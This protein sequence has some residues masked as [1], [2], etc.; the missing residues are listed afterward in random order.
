M[1]PWADPGGPPIRAAEYWKKAGWIEGETLLV[2]RRYADFRTERFADFAGELLRNGAELLYTWGNE[3]TVAAMRATATVPIVF[4]NVAFPVESGVVDSLARPGRNATGFAHFDGVESS[5]KFTEL[6][7]AL[8]PKAKRLA[9][10]TT[11]VE[12]RMLSPKG[13]ED[14]LTKTT[15]VVAGLGLERTIHRVRRIEEVHGALAAAAAGHA[16]V[17]YCAGWEY[18]G[19]AGQVVDFARRQRWVS[20]T[21]MGALFDAG[22]LICHTVNSAEFGRSFERVREMTDRIL[23]GARPADIPVELPRSI[24]IAFNLREARALGLTV[25]QSLLLRADRVVE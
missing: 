20:A 11:E 4:N 16:E 15:A 21:P 23:R 12:L 22:L 25:P 2:D 9:V 10:L 13:G 8:A 3:A 17:V 24:E 6:L 5:L 14:I 1:Y 19:V 7:R 18:V